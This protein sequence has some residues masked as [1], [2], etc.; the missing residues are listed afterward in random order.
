MI[1]FCKSCLKFSYLLSMEL[2]W[3]LSSD[4]ALF[5]IFIFQGPLY[6]LSCSV[7]TVLLLSAL[8]YLEDI[9]RIES[10]KGRK[11]LY[12]LETRHAGMN[13]FKVW[14]VSAMPGG[15]AFFGVSG[16]QSIFCQQFNVIHYKNR[17]TSIKW[18][19]SHSF[20]VC[21]IKSCKTISLDFVFPL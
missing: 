7:R 19:I 17:F 6:T 20:I 16:N 8:A 2:V 1:E 14:F 12:S 5:R 13:F 18:S 3:G 21:V 4:L 11:S 9:G 15:G 10:S